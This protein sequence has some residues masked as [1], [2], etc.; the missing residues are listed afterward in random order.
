MRTRGLRRTYSAPMPL[1]PYILCA[2]MVSRS[3]L[4]F[5]R[6][7]STL[8]AACTASQWKMMPLARQISP[9]SA[10]GWITPISLFTIMT[11]TTIVSGRIAALSFS[12]STRPSGSGSR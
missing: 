12:R 5:A 11:E 9:I 6:S 10:I 3:T 7:M 4:S 2:V 8:P 1:G